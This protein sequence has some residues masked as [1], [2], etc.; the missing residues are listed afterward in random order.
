M[1]HN[2]YQFRERRQI[3]QRKRQ[4]ART[5][6]LR[7]NRFNELRVETEREAPVTDAMLVSA[8]KTVAIIT[9]Q[10]CARRKH[11]GSPSRAV[12]KGPTGHDGDAHAAV[13]LFEWPV[14]RPGRTTNVVH[15]PTVS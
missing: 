1:S 14:A 12:R 5:P 8:L 11:S 3:R 4:L 7:H 15:P 9:Q 13:L 6:Q 10:R 2:G